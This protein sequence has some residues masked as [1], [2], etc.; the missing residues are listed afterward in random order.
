MT[1]DFTKHCPALIEKL[2]ATIGTR[3]KY[4]FEEITDDV[5]AFKMISENSSEVMADSAE[6]ACMMTSLLL[7]LF[8]SGSCH[9][10]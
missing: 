8:P 6:S 7:L 3:L 5:I 1:L 10:G 2:N 9:V 4:R